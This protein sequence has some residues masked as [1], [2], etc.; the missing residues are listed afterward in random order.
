M[1]PSPLLLADAIKVL[2]ASSELLNDVTVSQAVHLITIASRLLGDIQHRRPSTDQHNDDPPARLS[3]QI[4]NVLSKLTEINPK[5]I[6]ICWEAFKDVVWASSTTE[7]L[8][9]TNTQAFRLYGLAHEFSKHSIFP[10]SQCCMTHGCRQYG[11]C[12]AVAEHRQVVLFTL[13]GAYPAYYTYLRCH[14]PS[15]CHTVYHYNYSVQDQTRYYH[16]RV[17]DIIQ[18]GAHH[19]IERS[20]INLFIN[21]QVAA[22]TSFTHC[23][24]IYNESI[25]PLSGYGDVIWPFNLAL[26]TE[27]VW[28]AVNTLALLEE[29]DDW[30]VEAMKA[31]HKRTVAY[32]QRDANHACKKCVH[33]WEDKDGKRCM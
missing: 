29:S 18:V 1:P 21:L 2:S 15:G 5:W 10:P 28:D 6:P 20:V 16:S 33:A 22:W 4:V 12:L 19:F 31:L 26:R 25:G 13:K 3:P 23:A 24:D 7:A 11:R 32:G 8:A 9:D 27:H 30:L 14:S 17:P